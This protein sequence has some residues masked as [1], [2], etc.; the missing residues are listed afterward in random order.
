MRLYFAR[1]LVI[2]GFFALCWASMQDSYSQQVTQVVQVPLPGQAPLPTQGGPEGQVPRGVEV[3][4]RGPIHEAFATPTGEPKPTGAVNKKPPA[5]LD[6]MAP[7]E[8]PEGDMTWIG[9][10]WAW[11][12]DRADYLWVSG[13]WRAKPQGKDWV[14]GYWR[15]QAE[16]WQ[17]VPGFWANAAT[18]EAPAQE[19]TYY[20]EP[21]APPQ[22]APPGDP[23]NAD[24]IYVPGNYYWYGDRYTWRAGYWTRGRA[25]Y[26]YVA[27]HYRWTPYGYVFV[28]GYWDLAVARRAASCTRPW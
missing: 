27:S 7:E 5:A 1:F 26:V 24:M 6:E 8:R 21:P 12:D 19:V 16:L 3:Q 28:P 18:K 2:A 4:A 22:L 11:D 17:W 9:G 14:P 20:P 23:P 25:G 10:Y 15:E 13:C